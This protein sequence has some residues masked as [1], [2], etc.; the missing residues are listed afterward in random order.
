MKKSIG[1][2]L[3]LLIAVLGSIAAVFVPAFLRNLH[4]SRLVEPLNGLNHIATRAA[5]QA[6][7]TPVQIAYPPSAPRTPALVPAGEAMVD[8]AGTWNHAT[9]KL[10]SFEKS[11][12]HYFSFEFESVNSP[13]GSHFYARAFGDLDGDGESSEFELLGETKPGEEPITYNIRMY[14]EVE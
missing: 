3:A 14:R 5:M 12:A 9:W 10:L 7:G 1:V 6:A 11:E 4:A 8:P 2:Q 13:T